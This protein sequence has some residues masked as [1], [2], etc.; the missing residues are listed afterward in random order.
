M[1]SVFS[2]DIA[3]VTSV[4]SPEGDNEKVVL[5]LALNGLRNSR[6]ISTCDGSSA[7]VISMLP[8]PTLRLP[9]HAYLAPGP[10]SGPM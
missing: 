8:S 6:S 3:H 5:F 4:A 1:S 7:S 9:D 10:E 2:P